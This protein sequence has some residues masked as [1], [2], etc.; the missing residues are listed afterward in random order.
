MTLDEQIDDAKAELE[1]LQIMAGQSEQVALDRLRELH[2]QR[3]EEERRQAR[4]NRENH[5]QECLARNGMQ[6]TKRSQAAYAFAWDEGHSSGFAEVRG[7]F[8]SIA[9]VLKTP[10]EPKERGE[11]I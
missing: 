7:Y 1:A 9:I 2:R 11:T 6:D 4:A 10:D 3:G 5:Y 8:D